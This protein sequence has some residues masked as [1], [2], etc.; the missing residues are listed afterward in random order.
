MFKK[1]TP[2]AIKEFKEN[3]HH[4]HEDRGPLFIEKPHDCDWDP[5]DP[6]PGAS[7]REKHA[8]KITSKSF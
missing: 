7:C 6:S 8:P 2:E 4:H 5:K 3:E 1:M